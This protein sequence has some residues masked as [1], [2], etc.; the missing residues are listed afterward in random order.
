[1]NLLSLF[2]IE[3]K[4]VNNQMPINRALLFLFMSQVHFLVEKSKDSISHSRQGWQYLVQR[5]LNNEFS[6]ELKLL[7]IE[8]NSNFFQRYR[9][10]LTNEYEIKED[11]RIYK[12]HLLPFQWLPTRQTI[13][14]MLIQAGSVLRYSTVNPHMAE[15]KLIPSVV[16]NYQAERGQKK[17]LTQ[18][19]VTSNKTKKKRCELI[20]D[21]V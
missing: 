1:M 4:F 19:R 8:L 21:F 5:I 18:K 15:S 2:Y 9:N 17:S 20:F 13:K 10:Q 11:Q 6:S 7:Q 14:S 12:V 16:L 3:N